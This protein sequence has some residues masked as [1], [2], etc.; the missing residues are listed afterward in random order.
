MAGGSAFPLFISCVRSFTLTTPQSLELLKRAL[1]LGGAA[2]STLAWLT[3]EV[4]GELLGLA[5]QNAVT[6]EVQNPTFGFVE[7]L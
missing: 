3:A 6:V 5:R 1:V 7:E 4:W 2:E